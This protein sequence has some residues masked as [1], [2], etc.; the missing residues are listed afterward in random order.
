MRSSYCSDQ[1]EAKIN[2]F[3]AKR[4]TAKTNREYQLLGEQIDAGQNGNHSA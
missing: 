4:N 1:S 2:D 3:E